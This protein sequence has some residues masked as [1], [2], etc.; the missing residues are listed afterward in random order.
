[1]KQSLNNNNNEKKIQIKELFQNIQIN[2][3]IMKN[4]KE[5]ITK[6]NIIQKQI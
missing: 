2:K 6:N 3:E 4:K 5:R 1:M